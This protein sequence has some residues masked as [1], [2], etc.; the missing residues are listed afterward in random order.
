MLIPTY[1]YDRLARLVVGSVKL[2][3]SVGLESIAAGNRNVADFVRQ[4]GAVPF[5]DSATVAAGQPTLFWHN[6][7]VAAP[8]YG[9]LHD[10]QWFGTAELAILN[11]TASRSSSI[12]DAVSQWG[13][14]MSVGLAIWGGCVVAG[15]VGGYSIDQKASHAVVGGVL[16]IIV[17]SIVARAVP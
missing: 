13:R 16:G 6:T 3:D 8:Y 9:L 14:S 4:M 11:P 5:V 17:G 12:D 10:I 1:I 7:S 15:A 2:D